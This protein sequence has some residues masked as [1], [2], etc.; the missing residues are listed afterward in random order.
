ML[1]KEDIE[2]SLKQDFL[3]KELQDFAIW[4]TGCGFDFA[5]NEYFNKKKYLLAENLHVFPVADVASDAVFESEN[6]IKYTRLFSDIHVGTELYIHPV[7]R[8][9]LE[10]EIKEFCELD[11][12][13]CLFSF[14]KGF[15]K[16]Q[17]FLL[18][19]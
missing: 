1:K 17:D 18:G 5:N 9:L 11:E 6:I 19:F 3:I 15:E 2:K 4:M 10:N 12:D 14:I 8:K 16:C 13:I 7:N